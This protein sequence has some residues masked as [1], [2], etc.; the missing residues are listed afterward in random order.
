MGMV[1]KNSWRRFQKGCGYAGTGSCDGDNGDG[2]RKMTYLP[3]LP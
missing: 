1:T 2:D 3:Q